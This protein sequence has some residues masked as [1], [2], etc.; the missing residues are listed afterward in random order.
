MPK[1]VNA[2]THQR[3]KARYNKR[4]RTLAFASGCR[5]SDEDAAAAVAHDMPD[6]E[7]SRLIGRSIQ[8]IH[9]CRIRRAV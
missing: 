2:E 5:W 9:M 1:R 7:L 3:Q 8:A 4:S 6:S